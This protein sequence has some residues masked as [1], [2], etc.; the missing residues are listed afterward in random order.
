MHSPEKNLFTT[1]KLR[2]MLKMQLDPWIRFAHYEMKGIPPHAA[3]C[4]PS[5]LGA[6]FL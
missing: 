5:L 3:P 1:V 6:V 2:A 4:L